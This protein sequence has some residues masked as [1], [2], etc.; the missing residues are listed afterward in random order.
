MSE[1][2]PCPFCGG[3]ATLWSDGYMEYVKCDV[4]GAKGQSCY[5][6][7]LAVRKWSTR[8]GCVPET[9]CHFIEYPDNNEDGYCSNC[10]EYMF[11][12][13]A[14]CPACGARVVSE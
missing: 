2:L 6:P 10:H 9:T 5:D 3:N 13:D 12:Q 8:A 7:Q 14:Y 11:K 1:L 4:C